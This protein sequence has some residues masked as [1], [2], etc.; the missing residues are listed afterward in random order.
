MFPGQKRGEWEPY[1]VRERPAPSITNGVHPP[2]PA[3]VEMKDVTTNGE[4]KPKADE[5]DETS[6]EEDPTSDEGAVYPIREGRIVDWSCFFA[7]LTHVFNTLSPPF[8]TPIMLIAQPAWT[9]QDHETVTQFF[10]EKF[11]T[12]AFCLMNAASAACYAYGVSNATVIDIGHEKVDV[13]AVSDFV[14]HD[15]GRGVAISGCGGEGLTYRLEEL[16]GSKGFTRNMCEQ[17]KKSNICEILPAGMPLPGN[18]ESASQITDPNPASEASTGAT[19]SGAAQRDNLQPQ[20]PRGPGAGTEVGEEA[21]N[22]EGEDE[23]GVLD[24][25]S[26][27]ASGKTSE[28]LARR[29]KEKAE[30]A[31]AKKGALADQ[32]AAARAARLP[33]SKRD[34]AT[35]S[36]EEYV[37]IESNGMTN[38]A[39]PTQ[40][41]KRD[42]EIGVERFLAATPNTSKDGTSN[43]GILDTIAATINRTILSVPEVAKRSDLWD[44]LIILGNGSR[45]KG[46]ELSLPSSWLGRV[47]SLYCNSSRLLY[48]SLQTYLF[49]SQSTFD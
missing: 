14:A 40:R 43:D 45:T 24:V 6:F 44:S 30:K 37:K 2:L 35:F 32:A 22:G 25:A 12:P 3:D 15:T 7:L 33:N 21:T 13:T 16:L 5:E 41:R 8:H 47:F 1:K 18:A 31:A 36:F 49:P 19:G 9:A 17:L 39:A 10:F 28:Y 4:E 20:A 46:T 42:I 27:V 11:K 34:R 48:R 26:I 23:E 29:E 38:G